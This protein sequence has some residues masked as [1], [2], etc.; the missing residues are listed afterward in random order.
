MWYIVCNYAS[1][2]NVV[3]GTSNNE[4]FINN[5]GQQVSGSPDVGIVS[6]LSTPPTTELRRGVAGLLTPSLSVKELQ[7]RAVSLVNHVRSEASDFL[8][9]LAAKIF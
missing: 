2:G 6:L 3:G 7:V 8:A 1:A 4:Y 5:V 9:A